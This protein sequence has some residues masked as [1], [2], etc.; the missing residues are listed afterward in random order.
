V[1]VIF[2]SVTTIVVV[3]LVLLLW[4]HLDRRKSLRMEAETKTPET[5]SETA[6]MEQP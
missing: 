3:G 1:S 6:A 5:R 4:H 2:Y